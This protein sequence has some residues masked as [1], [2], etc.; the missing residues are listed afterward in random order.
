MSPGEY[1]I[2]RDVI[3]VADAVPIREISRMTGINTVTLRAWERRYGL[4]KPQRTQKGHR[5]YSKDDV[6]RVREIQIWLK[7][8]LA[9][10]KVN[11]ILSTQTQ[12]AGEVSVDSVWLELQQQLD[13]IIGQFN[14][15]KLEH[16]LEDLLAL[17]PSEM[18][19]DELFLPLFT[20]LKEEGASNPARLAFFKTVLAEHL[21]AVQYRQR[22]LVHGARVLLVSST[23]NESSPLP[24]LLSYALLAN[25]QPTEFL[26]YLDVEEAVLVAEALAT[27]LLVIC[28]YE[29]LDATELQRYLKYWHEKMSSSI[30]LV[31]HIAHLYRAVYGLSHPYVK[32]CDTQQE[33]IVWIN[34][35]SQSNYHE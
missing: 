33:A 26:H 2:Q 3:G 22:H 19:A 35:F 23:T 9:I 21:Y 5:L 31:G 27:D 17:Y 29:S 24:L 10:S 28:G 1:T 14:R 8:G 13:K 25:N 12:G 30:L 16:A 4:L 15:R 34:G 18:L 11:A 20:Q 7:R 6:A 32:A